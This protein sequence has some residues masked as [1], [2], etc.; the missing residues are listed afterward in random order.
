MRPLLC[1]WEP[2]L[3]S[4]FICSQSVTKLRLQIV[5]YPQIYHLPFT[6]ASKFNA[7]QSVI[8]NPICSYNNPHSRIVE[9]K[10]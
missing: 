5:F 4:P 3:L 1:L 6:E 9:N 10:E 2:S 7:Y 8:L